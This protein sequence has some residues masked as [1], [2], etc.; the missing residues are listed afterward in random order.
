MF[1][2]YKYKLDSFFFSLALSMR[3]N[4][5]NYKIAGKAMNQIVNVIS[6]I[7][8]YVN[9]HYLCV[10]LDRLQHE[11]CCN[12]NGQHMYILVNT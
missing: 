12:G 11:T 1:S 4:L 8:F 9:H 6:G 5:I 2:Q 7:L 3:E 10:N